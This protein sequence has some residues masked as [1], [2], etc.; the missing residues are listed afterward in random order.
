MCQTP[1]A[2]TAKFLIR[3]IPHFYLDIAL[4]FLGYTDLIIPNN[5]LLLDITGIMSRCNV[6]I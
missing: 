2:K 1:L 4:V 6:V 3:L 5:I